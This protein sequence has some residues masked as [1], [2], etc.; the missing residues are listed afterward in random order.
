MSRLQGHVALL[1]VLYG[2]MIAAGSGGSARAQPVASSSVP[3]PSGSGSESP[4]TIVGRLVQDALENN[5]T[6]KQE[7]ISL[8]QRRA[9]LAQTQGQ[10]LPSLDLKARYTRSRGGRTIDFPVGDAVNPAYRALDQMNPN[11]PFPRLQN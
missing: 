7:R 3:S 11:R 1:L 5:L 8:E 2:I 9:A 4:K 6:L 10:Y